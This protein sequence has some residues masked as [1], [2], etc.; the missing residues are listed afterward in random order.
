MRQ[1]LVVL[2][3]PASLLVADV[4]GSWHECGRPG[5]RRRCGPRPRR[6]PRRWLLR[7]QI[8]LWPRLLRLSGLVRGGGG[9][10]VWLRV[11]VR[12]RLPLWIPLL[13]L[14]L[15]IPGLRRCERRTAARRTSGGAGRWT[16]PRSPRVRRCRA[17]PATDSDAL[18][19]PRSSQCSCR[20]NGVQTTQNGLW[21][22]PVLRVVAGCSYTFDVKAEWTGPNGKVVQFLNG[23]FRSR[24]IVVRHRFPDSPPLTMRCTA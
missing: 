22:V 2:V 20:I 8:R 11:G 1:R 17:G 9:H 5:P 15:W 21:P 18:Q 7:R 3:L 12:I 16:G 19:H 13:P 4:L 14:R 23:A 6:R 24:R 10:R